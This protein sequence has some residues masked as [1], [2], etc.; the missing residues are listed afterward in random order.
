[1]LS[2]SSTCTKIRVA[3]I[4]TTRSHH[5]LRIER[6]G[7]ALRV[8]FHFTDCRRRCHRH[9]HYCRRHLIVVVAISS[10]SLPSHRCHCHL[11]VVIAISSLLLLCYCCPYSS[12]V[13]IIILLPICHCHLR[14]LLVTMELWMLVVSCTDLALTGCQLSGVTVKMMVPVS[15]VTG[16]STSLVMHDQV[17]YFW[18]TNQQQTLGMLSCCCSN[19]A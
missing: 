6:T 10:L 19:W 14:C 12:L 8:S 7:R 15:V 5:M 9:F 2:T 16:G 17:C 1:M 11:I 13:A 18:I 3:T 4:L